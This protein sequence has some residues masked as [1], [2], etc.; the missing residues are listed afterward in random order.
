MSTPDVWIPVKAAAALVGRD[1]SRIRHWI[2]E[3]RLRVLDDA[4]VTHVEVHEVRELEMLMHSRRRN[5]R[6]AHGG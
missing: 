2:R 6:T 4:E 5:L 3:G 1:P